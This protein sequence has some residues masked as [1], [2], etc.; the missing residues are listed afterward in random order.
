MSE[1]PSESS[2]PL[3]ERC[4]DRDWGFAM[5]EGDRFFQQ[6]S[7]VFKTMRALARRLDE[8]AIPYA[9]IGGMALYA[10]GF[11]RFTEDVDVLV[12]P[13]GLKSIHEHLEGRGYLPPFQGSKQLRDTEH[14]VRI[15]FLLTGTYPGDGRPK[16]VCVPDPKDTAVEK[17]G[18]KVLNLPRL[19]ELKLASGMTGGTT[20]LKD[21]ADVV[22]LIERLQLPAEFAE[23]LDAYVRSKFMELWDG[24]R[25]AP[26][27][28]DNDRP[29]S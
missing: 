21:F 29:V 2:T 5:D 28:P 26:L 25:N 14:G 23:Q 1:H 19:V 27:P 8:L 22:A 16:P 15:E 18:I 12:T 20:R 4:L 17:A 24:V 9:I 11:R 7:A 6:D 13:T 3:Y 10:H